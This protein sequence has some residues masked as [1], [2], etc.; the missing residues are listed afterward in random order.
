MAVWVKSEEEA[1]GGDHLHYNLHPALA[2]L[3]QARSPS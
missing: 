1:T 2:D 3:A